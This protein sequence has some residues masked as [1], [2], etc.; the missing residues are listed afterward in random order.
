MVLQ[1]GWFGS[2]SIVSS[3]AP[4]ITTPI[5]CIVTPVTFV[6]AVT[7]VTLRLLRLRLLQCVTKQFSGGLKKVR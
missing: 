4:A 7:S 6:T 2:Q 3:I 5:I 1:T